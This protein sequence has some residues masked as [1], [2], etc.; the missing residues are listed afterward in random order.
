M[1][2][3]NLIIFLLVS[4][5]FSNAQDFELVNVKK[6]TINM[7]DVNGKKQGKW[8]IMG[9]HK[10]GSCYKEMQ[11]IEEGL[12]KDNKRIGVWTEYYCNSNVKSKIPYIG[13]RPS[14]QIIFYYEN[15][16]VR[17]EGTWTNNRWVGNYKFNYDDGTILECV[18]DDKGK[19]ISRK[20]ISPSKKK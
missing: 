16:M 18:F 5:L 1:K 8:I 17:E 7:T 13:G 6:D 9:Y 3:L 19:E 11:K 14:G 15:G 12:Y 20:T 2:T 10:K 4:F